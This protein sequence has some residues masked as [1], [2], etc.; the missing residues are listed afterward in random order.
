MIVERRSTGSVVVET[1]GHET[2]ANMSQDHVVPA[3]KRSG[4]PSIKPKIAEGLT[5]VEQMFAHNSRKHEYQEIAG[6]VK[7]NNLSA[8]LL[9]CCTC[10]L[11]F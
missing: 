11:F 2:T 5:S 4:N 3:E 6:Q 10:F 9:D 1:E 8:Y 7:N